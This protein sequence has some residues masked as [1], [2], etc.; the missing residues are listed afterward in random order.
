MIEFEISENLKRILKKLR[1]KD[2]VKYEALMKKIEEVISSPDPDHYKNLKYDLKEYKRV[3]V[4]SFVP[5]FR[6]LRYKIYFEDF[7][8]HNNIY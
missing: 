6:F 2:R 1:K 8:H 7:D 5:V 3:H 4:G